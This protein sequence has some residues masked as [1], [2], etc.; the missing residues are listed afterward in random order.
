MPLPHSNRASSWLRH[1]VAA[2]ILLA[3]ALRAQEPVQQQTSPP[4]TSSVAQTEIQPLLGLRLPADAKWHPLTVSER[5]HLVARQNFMSPVS[6][7][8]PAL[9]TLGSSVS[10][11][12][13]LW[14]RTLGGTAKL[15]ASYWVAAGTQD[16]VEAAGASLTG[17]DIRYIACRCT[18][19]WRRSGHALSQTMFTYDKNGKLSFS[20]PR[21]AGYFAASALVTYTIY[22]EAARTRSRF[23]ET[24]TSQ[25]YFGAVGAMFQEF[26][27]DIGRLFKKKRK[28]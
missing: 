27:P 22:P 20:F 16:A 1:A 13:S 8:R 10:R 3:P 4:A 23:L 25:I 17:Q 5:W 9:A 11:D 21:V 26:G 7:T 12:T 2:T 28:P 18:G 14:P 24:G 19:F 15:Y 6:L